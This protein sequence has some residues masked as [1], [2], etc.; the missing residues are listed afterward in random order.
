[1]FEFAWAD[2]STNDLWEL[3]ASCDNFLLKTY[4]TTPAY[5]MIG[6]DATSFAES[7]R[8]KSAQVKVRGLKQGATSGVGASDPVSFA[9]AEQD[10]QGGIYYWSNVCSQ[11]QTSD[12]AIYRFDFGAPKE[13]A[14]YY[15]PYL[16]GSNNS[17]TCVGCHSVS[18]DGKS[19]TVRL[20]GGNSNTLRVLDAVTLAT[21]FTKSLSSAY[22]VFSP[23]GNTFIND[24]NG[25]L[26]LY[27]AATGS[28]VGPNSG[29]LPLTNAAQPDWSSDSSKVVAVLMGGGNDVWATNGSIA[30]VPY[31]G[32]T[33]GF[34]SPTTI[35][36]S[37]GTVDNYYPCFTPDG[38]YI[39]YNVAASGSSYNNLDARLML[40]PVA[41]GTPIALTKSQPATNKRHSWPRVS[42]FLKSEKGDSLVWFTF[43]ST[44]APVTGNLAT[45]KPSQIYM[46]AIRLP[47]GGTP[48]QY[49]SFHLPYQVLT[50]CNHIAQWTQVI[51]T[52]M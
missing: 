4:L 11:V 22:T 46:A 40:V 26:T 20:D 21:R 29:K 35:V 37:T 41:G 48:V 36:T 45:D 25:V 31:N 16:S 23:D 49:A 8:G 28:T 14:A 9:F 3:S 2:A 13:A 32:T 6:T 52:P 12:S 1:M 10:V 43:S 33:S 17:G 51:V 5:V 27:D 7:C 30:V 39:I 38:G 47:S 19:L 42:P 24:N 15:G 34:G 44:V 18:R 50:R